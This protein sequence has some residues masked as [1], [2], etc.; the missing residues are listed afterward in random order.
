LNWQLYCYQQA[1]FQIEIDLGFYRNG[2]SRDVTI[3][4]ILIKSVHTA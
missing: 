2:R 1:R 3:G 4:F